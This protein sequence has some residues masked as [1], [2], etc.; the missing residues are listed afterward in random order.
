[1]RI[2]IFLTCAAVAALAGCGTPGAPLPPSLEIPKPVSDLKAVRKGDTVT[3]SWSASTETT[4]GELIRKAGH[5]QLSRTLAGRAAQ[6]AELPLEPALKD[7]QPQ[8]PT[9]KDSIASLL[10]SPPSDFAEYRVLS[11]SHSGR[12]D[13]PSNLAAV[14]LVP[15]PA[16]PQRLQVVAVPR[17]ISFTWDQAWPPQNRTHLNAQYVYRIMRRSEESK[18]PV[19]VAQANAGNEAI[20][21]VD[22]TIEWQKHYEYWITPVTLWQGT[23]IKGEVEGDDS[24][25]VSIFADDKFPPSVPAGLQAVFSGTTQQPFID[26]TWIPDTEPDLAGYN[27]YRHVSGEALV[28]INSELIKTPSFRDTD[29][30]PGTK[31]F[32]SVSALDLRA[33]ESA[34]SQEASETA[35]Q[36]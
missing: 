10:P 18:T 17:G 21:F 35:P 34:R 20:G 16:A 24:P 5:M 26:L 14:P 6:I 8:A 31:Y 25:V 7:E 23:V 1:M 3:L 33:N 32:Y 29:V 11:Q 28:K 4:D 13:K 27:V 22:T 9:V 30:K 36:E 2:L 12:S 19:L 15:T